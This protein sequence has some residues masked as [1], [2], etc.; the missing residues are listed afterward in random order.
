MGTMF[1]PSRTFCLTL[2]ATNGDICFL[3]QRETG[4]EGVAVATK[5][6]VSFCSF[7]DAHLCSI[8]RARCWW[9]SEGEKNTKYFLNV[10]KCHYKQGKISQLKLDVST[11]K[12]IL[13]E[14]ENFYKRLYSSNKCSQ[15]NW[16]ISSS[17]VRKQIKNLT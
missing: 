7:C 1:V 5:L 6:R 9:H 14:C 16:Q 15:M 12:E 17:S 2:K 13:N 8:L 4:A 11:D 3:W 10:E